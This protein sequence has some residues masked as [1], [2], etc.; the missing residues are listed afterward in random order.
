MSGIIL[1]FALNMDLQPVKI[2]IA[3]WP[4]DQELIQSVRKQVFVLEQGIEA[5]LE[6]DGRDAQCQHLLALTPAGDAAGTVRLQAD[7]HIGRLAVISRYR[8]RGIATALLNYLLRMTAKQGMTH[9]YLHA[10][11]TAI[12]FYEAFGFNNQ[13]SQFMEAGLLHQPMVYSVRPKNISAE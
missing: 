3:A 5:S 9:L 6:W 1:I 10:Q 7:G 4:D 13:G 2:K 8:K 12:S 11:I